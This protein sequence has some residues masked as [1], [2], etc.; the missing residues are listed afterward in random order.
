[1]PELLEIER[2]RKCYGP[3]T[4]LNN[5]SLSLPEH[6]TTCLIGASGSG[7]STLLRCIN[8]LESIQDGSISF[9]GE[10]VSGFGVDLNY[11]RRNIGMV[12]QGYNLFPHMTVLENVMLAPMHV[13][14]TAKAEAGAPL[15]NCWKRWALPRRR[16]VTPTG[17][18]AVSN[19][20]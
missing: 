3:T 4:V 14:G 13:Y 12:F 5:I 7:K 15:L 11:V 19:S 6:S 10:E 18:P 20:V 1:M 16:R 8:G 17:S 2:V 9:D